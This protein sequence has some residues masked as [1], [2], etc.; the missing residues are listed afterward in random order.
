MGGDGWCS[1]VGWGDVWCSE[2][3]W[4]VMVGTVGW[5]GGCRGS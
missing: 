3:E 5:R 2:V 1:E 4:G